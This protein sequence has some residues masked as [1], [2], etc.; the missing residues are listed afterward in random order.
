MEFKDIYPVKWVVKR[1]WRRISNTWPFLFVTFVGPLFAFF[2]VTW[3]F[4]SNVPRDMPVA[5]VDMDHTSTSR[6]L[7][8]MTDATSIAAVNRSFVSLEEAHNAMDKGLLDAILYIPD[9]TEKD[10]IRGQSASVALYLNNANVVKGGLLNSGIRKALGTFSA[11]VKLRQQFNKGLNSNQAMAKVM[12]IQLRSIL[13]FN[14]YISYSYYL[15]AG[16]LPVMLIV[17]ILLGTIYSVGTE[18]LRGTGPHWLYTA[19]GSMMY[20]L[21]GKLLPFTIIYF[22]M[23]LFMNF[24]L[25][26]RMGMPLRGNYLLFMFSELLLILCYQFLAIFLVGLTG[27]L[28]LSLSL[29]SGYSMLAL[30]YSGLTFPAIGMPIIGQ[31]LTYVF[32]YTFWLKILMGQSLRGEPTIN[33][34]APMFAL[35]LFMGLGLALIPRLKYMLLQPEHWGKQ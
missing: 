18:L 32:P 29:G 9:G 28:R 20:A 15:T 19:R 11:G 13:L 3:V 4:S 6:L 12:P 33:M 17:F 25:F 1:E 7:A 23:A 24:I 31:I 14:P 26:G 27:N 35:I 34:L 16:L 2:L 30:T 5:V 21:I 10:I 8:R 22:A